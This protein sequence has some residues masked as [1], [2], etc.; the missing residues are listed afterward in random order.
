MRSKASLFLMEQLVMV[1]VF[2][3]AAALCLRVFAH[4]DALSQ[5]IACRDE[6]VRIAQ[7]A[8]EILKDTGDPDLAE[9][10]VDSGS[11]CVEISEENSGITGLSQATI[12][13]YD[14]ESLLFSLQTGWQE[15][16]P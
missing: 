1:L 7:N 13:V 14:E 2:A 8:A 4:A 15:V 12:L 10:R 3:L 16:T 5:Q 11:F 6:A 9:Q